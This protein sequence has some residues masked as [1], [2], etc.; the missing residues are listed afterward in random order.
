VTTF[1]IF[2]RR[3]NAWLW[4]APL[5]IPGEAHDYEPWKNKFESQ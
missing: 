4:M 3:V 1:T 2:T 5:T